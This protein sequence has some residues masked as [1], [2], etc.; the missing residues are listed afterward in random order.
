MIKIIEVAVSMLILMTGIKV[1]DF[2][3]P[4]MLEVHLSN[5]DIS[6]IKVNKQNSYSCP[7]NCSAIHYHDALLTNNSQL[8]SNYSLYSSKDESNLKLNNTKVVRIF[9]IQEEKSYSKKKNKIN[10][11]KRKVDIDYFIKK[12][13]L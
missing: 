7:S 3:K 4:S 6:H 2:Y 1:G 8:N 13:N 9:E 5:G 10:M 11:Q 12:Y